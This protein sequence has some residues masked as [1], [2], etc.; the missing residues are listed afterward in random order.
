M[1]TNFKA[2]GF[3]FPEDPEVLSVSEKVNA[4]LALAILAPSTHNIQPWLVEKYSESEL[5]VT[6][7]RSRILPAADPYGRDLLQSLG[8]FIENVA[9]ASKQ[10][11]LQVNFIE[12]FENDVSNTSI[13]ISFRSIHKTTQP[14]TDMWKMMYYAIP[15]RKNSRVLFDT[16]KE[17]P[18]SLVATMGDLN[19]MPEELGVLVFN[20]ESEKRYLAT[21]TGQAVYATQSKKAFRNEFAKIVHNNITKSKIG[22]PAYSFGLSLIPSLF[23]RFVFGNFNISRALKKI[24]EKAMSACSAVVIITSK[25]NT[26]ESWYN[27]GRLF[28]RISLFL[29]AKGVK[30]SVHIAAAEVETYANELMLHIN[31]RN[32][33]QMIFRVGYSNKQVKHTPR[34]PLEDFI[35]K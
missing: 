1:K 35:V 2:W 22:M 12:S 14:D 19:D 26:K 21:I 7:N 6:V 18:E 23:A 34:A 17:L 20:Q 8:C 24:N 29:T 5:G 11:H 32:R 28:E 27:V 3:S 31:S 30:V 10:L 4:C 33:P 13:H 16:S 15:D 9:I 25:N